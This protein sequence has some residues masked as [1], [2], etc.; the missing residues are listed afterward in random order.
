MSRELERVLQLRDDRAHRDGGA[1]VH[2]VRWPDE[3]ATETIYSTVHDSA[4]HG[5]QG[6]RRREDEGRMGGMQGGG[7]R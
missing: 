1:G 7:S 3:R 5:G 4:G 6:E 2:L